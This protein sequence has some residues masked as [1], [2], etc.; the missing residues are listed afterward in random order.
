MEISERKKKNAYRFDR[1]G[2]GGRFKAG[3]RIVG[4]FIGNLRLFKGETNRGLITYYLTQDSVRA[5][6]KSHEA[7]EKRGK[8]GERERDSVAK[9]D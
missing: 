9:Q 3:I 1:K 2:L 5:I 6:E 7:G 8:G 4:S